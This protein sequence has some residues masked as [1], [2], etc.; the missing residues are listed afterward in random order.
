VKK[1]N[2]ILFIGS[3]IVLGGVAGRPRVINAFN[4]PPRVIQGGLFTG[5]LG[6]GSHCPNNS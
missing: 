1:K 5:Q 3:L 6:V 2:C 4:V